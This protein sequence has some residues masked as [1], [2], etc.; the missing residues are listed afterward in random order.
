[1]PSIGDLIS[2]LFWLSWYT[3]GYILGTNPWE[4]VVEYRNKLDGWFRQLRAWIDAR[5]SW[6]YDTLVAWAQGWFTWLDDWR[7]WLRD[8][9]N[10]VQ[11][12][13][14]NTAT[15]VVNWVFTHGSKLAY[16]VNN[17]YT[18]LKW[19]WADPYNAFRY[20][21]GTAW[22]WWRWFYGWAG[23]KLAYFFNN[24]YGWVTWFW[25]DPVNAIRYYLG[26]A[27]DW[28]FAVWSDFV[29][30]LDRATG[31]AVTWL[32]WFFSDPINALRYYIG[33]A[34]DLLWSIASDP[35]AWLLGILGDAW[36]YWYNTW[37]LYG[38]ILST[39]LSNPGEFIL[40]AVRELFL[41]WLEELVSENW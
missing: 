22:D 1:M 33:A 14:D 4:R 13:I 31:G 12:W 6:V 17:V 9:V 32:R 30:W 38:A 5:V 34:L 39:F 8:R 40:A 35:L 2:W 20:Y 36:T 3:T 16:F 19:F 27:V 18:W 15:P 41:D 28:L 24:V 10:A 21:L 26:P 25:N 11:D 29:G 37:S 7:V 23:Q